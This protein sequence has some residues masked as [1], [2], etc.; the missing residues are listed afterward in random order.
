[1]SPK[2]HRI[3]QK[4]GK[5]AY[6]GGGRAEAITIDSNIVKVSVTTQIPLAGTYI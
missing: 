2:V 3:S 4:A 1:M 6:Q 5:D